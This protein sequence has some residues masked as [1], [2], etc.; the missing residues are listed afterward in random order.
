MKQQHLA[1]VPV[2]VYFYDVDMTRTAFFTNHLKWIDSVAFP[3]YCRKS[4]IKWNH[5]IEN[6]VDLAIAHLSIDYKNPI[7]MDD[8]IMVCITDVQ[9]GRTSMTVYGSLYREQTLIA[10]GK[11]VYTF[12]DMNTRQ[13][14]PVPELVREKVE[15]FQ[16]EG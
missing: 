4:G 16:T 8:I 15:A 2:T 9:L 12:V 3:E 1:A 6:N 5:L 13:S 10:E 7:F 14:I 11:I